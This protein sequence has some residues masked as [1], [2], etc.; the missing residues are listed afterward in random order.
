MVLKVGISVISTLRTVWGDTMQTNCTEAIY[1]LLGSVLLY[2]QFGIEGSS[3]SFSTLD[4]GDWYPPRYRSWRLRCQSGEG[5]NPPYF[6][7]QD[8]LTCN[9]LLFN[10]NTNSRIHQNNAILTTEG[11]HLDHAGTEGGHDVNRLTHT[12]ITRSRA[13]STPNPLTEDAP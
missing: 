8:W 7:H 2:H 11:G 12:N 9:H 6:H 13:S 4:Q 1:A 10:H 3:Q 5:Q